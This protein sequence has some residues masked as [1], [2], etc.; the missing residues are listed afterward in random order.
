MTSVSSST[1]FAVFL[2][3]GAIAYGGPTMIASLRQECVGKR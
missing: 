2:R 3:L 1:L